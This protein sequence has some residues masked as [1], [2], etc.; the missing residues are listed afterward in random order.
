MKK[1]IVAMFVSMC[2]IGQVY[3]KTTNTIIN[4]TAIVVN[5]KNV[6]GPEVKAPKLV[7]IIGNWYVGVE[8]GKDVAYT[9][10]SKGWFGYA[11]VTYDGTLLD[12]TKK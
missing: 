6:F 3:A 11:T 7:H 10:T 8:G 2:F 4:P 5:E 12:F 9:N 1:V